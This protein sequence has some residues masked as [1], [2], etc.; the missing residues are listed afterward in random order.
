MNYS[1][2]IVGGFTALI[3]VW[4]FAYARKDYKGPT[5]VVEDIVTESKS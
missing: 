5:V 3:A 1:C 4:W 2:P